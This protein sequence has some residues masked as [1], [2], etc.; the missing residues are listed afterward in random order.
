MFNAHSWLF[1]M[2]AVN[3]ADEQKMIYYKHDKGSN[4]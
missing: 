3:R 2:L 4:V 1:T